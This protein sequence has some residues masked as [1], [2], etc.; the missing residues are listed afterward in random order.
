MGCWAARGIAEVCVEEEGREKSVVRHGK[1]EE[2]ERK[3][4]EGKGR[5]TSDMGKLRKRRKVKK[6]K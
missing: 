1:T 3:G 4:G 6:E 2:R 5:R